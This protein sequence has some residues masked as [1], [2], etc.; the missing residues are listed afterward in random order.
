[1]HPPFNNPA[2]RR[3]LLGAFD[4]ADTMTAV[5]GADRR[6]WRDRIGLFGPASPIANDV[7][8]E[9]MS[10]PHDYRK[11]KSD[12]DAAGYH[13]EKVVVLGVGGNSFLPMIGQVGADALRRAGMDIDFQVMDAGTLVRRMQNKAALD[14]GGWNVTF[15]I[16]DCVMTANPGT[17]FFARGNGEKAGFGWPTSPEL[18]GLRAA[19]LDSDNLDAE[20]RIARDMQSQLWRDVPYVPLGHWVRYTAHRRDLVDIPRGF[21]AFYGVRR[22]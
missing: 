6:Y 22:V 8:V 11:V 13:G 9:V 21:A 12:L 5:A 7:G 18:E 16:M 20:K 1:L 10:P 2:A 19:W 14:Q 4:Q 17:N 15:F 3:A